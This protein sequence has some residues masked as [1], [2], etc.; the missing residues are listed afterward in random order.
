[1]R[2]VSVSAARF[3]AEHAHE[4]IV[5]GDVADHVG[6]SPFHLARVFEQHLGVS[7]GQYLAAHRFQCAKELLLAGD[8]QVIDVCFAVGFSSVGTFT[9][10][11]T[12]AVGVSPTA[13][14]RLPDVM[15]ASRPEPVHIP[16]DARHGGVVTGSVHLSDVAAAV[17]GHTVEIYVGLFR[18]RAA[19]G[20][21]IS[22]SLLGGTREF[23]LTGVPAGVYWLLATA[24]PARDDPCKQL[25][26]VRGVVGAFPRPL[27]VGADGQRLH[28]DVSLDLAD[29][30]LTPVVVA[31]PSLVI[32]SAQD[33]RRHG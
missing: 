23:M 33:W 10:R 16:G 12:A 18:R 3:L 5:L 14:R 27:R 22:G 19:S 15:A 1:M 11:F 24:L 7:P 17:L 20:F 26:P 21:P 29:D 9:R 30:W 2:H 28:H 4:P 25:L 32:G 13:L 8:E 31:L 6:Y